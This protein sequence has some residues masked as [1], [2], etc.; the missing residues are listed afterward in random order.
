VFRISFERGTWHRRGIERKE[1]PE[2]YTC[3]NSVKGRD[4]VQGPAYIHVVEQ[5]KQCA[6]FNCSQRDL[7]LQSHSEDLAKIYEAILVPDERKQL[8]ADSQDFVV[9]EMIGFR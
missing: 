3:P 8:T 1:A 7:P 2:E 4:P 6:A 5:W 9:G